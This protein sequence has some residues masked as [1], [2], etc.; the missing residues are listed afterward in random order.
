MLIF[1]VFDSSTLLP[2]RAAELPPLESE[3]ED[4]EGNEFN[5]ALISE[6]FITK[7][8]NEPQKELNLS[9]LSLLEESKKE[10]DQKIINHEIP[11]VTQPPQKQLIVEHHNKP[12]LFSC[13]ATKFSSR[14]CRTTVLRDKSIQDPPKSIPFHFNGLS[15]SHSNERLDK[16]NNQISLDDEKTDSPDPVNHLKKEILKNSERNNRLLTRNFNTQETINSRSNSNSIKIISS[17]SDNTTSSK[18][19][20]STTSTASSSTQNQQQQPH[21]TNFMTPQVKFQIP[22]SSNRKTG[23]RLNNLKSNQ[24]RSVI[25]DEFR[26]QK[27][28]FSTPIPT[29]K[30]PVVTSL[31]GNNSISLT[32]D[33]GDL[34]K[35]PSPTKSVHVVEK[36]LSP[37]KENEKNQKEVPSSE[38]TKGNEFKMEINGKGYLILKKIGLGGSSSVYLAKDLTTNVECALKVSL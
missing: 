24:S 4:E 30:P 11:E 1:C 34:I 32:F 8:E 9:S 37:V 33:G 17:D 25:E 12:S 16:E 22:I 7:S 23:P 10:E 21:D 26:R 38:E 29:S 3:S 27:I 13:R 20:T 18:T 15:K 28:L 5:M 2:R 36:R 31:F 6:S 19:Q 35:T 14:Q